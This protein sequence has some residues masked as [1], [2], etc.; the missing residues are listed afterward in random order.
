[1][2]QPDTFGSIIGVAPMNDKHSRQSNEYDF[3]LSK[4]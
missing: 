4:K 3:Y 1:M 2:I